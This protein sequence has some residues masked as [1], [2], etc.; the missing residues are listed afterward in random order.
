VLLAL[1]NAEGVP[2]LQAQAISA[3]D[4]GKHWVLEAVIGQQ[5]ASAKKRQ[6]IHAPKQFI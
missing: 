4:Q 3:R 2:T 1:L 5:S 6:R